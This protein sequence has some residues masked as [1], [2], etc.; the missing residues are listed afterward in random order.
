[1][2]RT[3]LGFA[4]INPTTQP[5]TA[6]GRQAGAGALAAA[7]A[8]VCLVLW[9]RAADSPTTT[10][11]STPAALSN[12]TAANY[13]LPVDA[14][15]ANRIFPPNAP[16]EIALYDATRV[17]EFQERTFSV[18][19]ATHRETLNRETGSPILPPFG[20]TP[21]VDVLTLDASASVPDVAGGDRQERLI[22]SARCRQL[23]DPVRLVVSILDP[24]A[25]V[26][27]SFDFQQSPPRELYQSTR[28]GGGNGRRLLETLGSTSYSTVPEELVFPLV[29]AMR[30]EPGRV[31][32]LRILASEWTDTTDPPRV[33]NAEITL[34]RPADPVALP[35]GTFPP[36]RLRAFNLLCE[37]GLRATCLVDE[38]EPNPLL[39]WET[40]DG[41]SLRLRGVVHEE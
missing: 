35:A 38:Q 15:W 31:Y 37:D 33:L 11:L 39:L 16:A 10:A 24:E 14:T 12:A 7:A 3:R 18:K 6:S 5:D 20:D 27:K 22:L 21:T 1:M 25:V 17:V 2:T 19:V 30:F 40:N 26:Y 23:S 36:D 13:L 28:M 4:C 29:R 32:G 8:F 9:C 34:F 41:R